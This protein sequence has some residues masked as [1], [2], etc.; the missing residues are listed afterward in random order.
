MSSRRI[1]VNL[2]D[3]VEAMDS[4]SE[5]MIE[6][7]LDVQ[8]GAVHVVNEEDRD[9]ADDDGETE[10]PAWQREAKALA[11]EIDSDPDRFVSVPQT[12]SHE[13]YR[14][15]EDFIPQVENQHLRERLADAIAGKGAF[16]RFK[17]VLLSHP[18]VRER[19]FAFEASVKRTW[20]ADWLATLGIE[21]T[22]KP[23]RPSAD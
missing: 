20:A 19:W 9:D 10:I 18:N 23:P 16:R 13:A 12:E 5:G 1:N 6:W 3:L 11:A 21:S 8:T 15:M 4:H 14:V 2:D 17:D 22:W 7:F